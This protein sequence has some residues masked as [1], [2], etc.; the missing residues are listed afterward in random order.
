LRN[1]LTKCQIIAVTSRS[2]FPNPF[3]GEIQYRS[4]SF[5]KD[6][7][8]LW[9][10]D[11]PDYIEDLKLNSNCSSNKNILAYLRPLKQ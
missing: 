4:I 3:T 10:D 8:W 6:S 2:N 9:L 5:R 11:L 7:M 1:Y